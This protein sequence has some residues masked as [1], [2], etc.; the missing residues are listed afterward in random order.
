MHFEIPVED[1]SGKRMLD[2]LVPRILGSEHSFRIFAY[3]GLGRIPRGM[4][5][6]ID[7]AK[8]VLLDRLRDALPGYSRSL[9]HAT[10]AVI[11]VCDLDA[12]CLKA[13]RGELLAMLND[14]DPRLPIRFCI[15]V[16]EG[17]AWLLGD[18]QAARSAYPKAR[19]QVLRDYEND[20]ICGTWEILAEA[21][22]PGGPAALKTQGVS[23]AGA[24]KS[25]WAEAIAPHIDPERNQS[26]SF[27]YFRGK[28]RELSGG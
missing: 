26:P 28:L 18:P 21:V 22:Y 4:K 6:E 3:K 25:R 1:Q 10:S 2:V 20:A 24:E 5:G 8:R 16:E 14:C 19:Q 17:G 15:A 9:D 7:P 11:V 27:H 12:R 13:F 23:A